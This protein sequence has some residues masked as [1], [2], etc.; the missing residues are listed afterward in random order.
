MA[1]EKTDWLAEG[2]GRCDGCRVV[3]DLGRGVLPRVSA[4]AQGDCRGVGTLGCD[5]LR[6][7]SFCGHDGLRAGSFRGPNGLHPENFRGAAC[8]ECDGSW[9]VGSEGLPS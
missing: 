8:V 3:S 5:G 4:I 9:S 2:G 6:A 1:G 7:E